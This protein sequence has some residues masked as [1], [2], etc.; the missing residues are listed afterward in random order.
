MGA[1]GALFVNTSG[2]GITGEE[3]ARALLYDYGVLAEPGNLFGS[4]SHIRLMFGGSDED[5]TEAARR[6]CTATKDLAENGR[7]VSCS[8]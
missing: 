6:I 5:V 1:G 7:Q 3:F 8:T 2:L 4:D